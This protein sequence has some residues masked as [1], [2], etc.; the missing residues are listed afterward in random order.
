MTH[1]PIVV[2]PLSSAL[3]A[4]ITGVDLSQPLDNRTAEAVHHAFLDHQ[5]IFF[6][7]QDITPDQHKDFAR[8]FGPLNVHPYVKALDGHPEILEVLKDT[9]DSRNFGGLWH[10]DLTFMEEPPLGSM[11]YALEVP[12]AGGDT[13]WASMYLAYERLSDGM[14]N[15]LDGL[16]G[17][18]SAGPVYGPREITA[19]RAIGTTIKLDQTEDAL[20]DVEHPVVRIHPET[21]RKCLFL[22]GGSYLRRFKDM[23]ED[24][25]APLIGYL[26]DFAV[27]PELTCR[28]RW[29]PGSF[30]FWD[31]RCTQHYALN[32]YHGER[33]LM[34]RVTIDGDRPV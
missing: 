32:D 24:E 34:H 18:H 31:N 19:D 2:T 29:Q 22:G 27:R 26:N 7:D 14:K 28:Y 8:R 4:E 13:L 1:Q 17:V 15:L 21:G 5:V 23:T 3:G 6:H 10:I 12:E 11:I 9:G 25:S 33:R 30:A 16:V 20:S